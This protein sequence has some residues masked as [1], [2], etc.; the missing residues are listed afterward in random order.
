MYFKLFLEFVHHR[1]L[2]ENVRDGFRIAGSGG[3][4]AVVLREFQRIWEQERV[5][6][7]S[8]ARRTVPGG[9]SRQ[10]LFLGTQVKLLEKGIVFQ[11]RHGDALGHRGN[12][13]GHA[14]HAFFILRRKKEGPQKR[15]MY[16]A[17]KC[18]LG[19]P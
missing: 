19:I 3:R 1:Q 10:A 7:R 9:H 14:S 2:P 15:T 16:P 13:F 6:A 17:P 5:K 8:S 12:R 18:K 11:S 4:L